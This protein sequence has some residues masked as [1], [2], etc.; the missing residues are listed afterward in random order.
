MKS[1]LQAQIDILDSNIKYVLPKIDLAKLNGKSIFMTGAT[2]FFGIWL[3]SAIRELNKNGTNVS[4]C[5][6]SRNP[7]LFQ[8]VHPQFSDQPWLSY[9]QGDIK[10]SPVISARFDF[11]LHGAT[12]TSMTAHANPQKML[13][14]IFIGTQKILEFARS[15]QVHRTLLISSGAVYGEQ[16]SAE[17][18]RMDDSKQACNTLMPYNAYGEGKR[19]MELMGAI[20]QQQYGI[21]TISARCFS[22]SGPGLPIDKHF[23]I[24]NFIRDALYLEKITIKGDGLAIRSYMHGA[25]LSVWLLNLMINGQSGESYN[26]GSDQPITIRDLAFKVRDLLAPGKTIQILNNGSTNL[27]HTSNYVPST[28]RA[29]QIGCSVWTNLDKS[30]QQAAEYQKFFQVN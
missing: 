17:P 28:T 9:I 10:F 2:G 7:T 11:L 26:V 22:F 12:E 30:I 13:D 25:D 24:G 15:C 23:A 20:F 4:V 16:S 21:D 27:S 1:L 29:R 18:L 6:L 14:D 8:H 3:L 5:V 19:L